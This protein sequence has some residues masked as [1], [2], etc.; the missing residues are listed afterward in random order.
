LK[1]DGLAII[2]DEIFAEIEIDNSIT[3]SKINASSTTSKKKRPITPL[4]K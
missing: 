1:E 3:S 2:K 4:L